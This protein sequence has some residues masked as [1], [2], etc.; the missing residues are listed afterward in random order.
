M[1]SGVGGPGGAGKFGGVPPTGASGAP[2]VPQPSSAERKGFGEA[3]AATGETVEPTATPPLERLRAGEIDLQQYVELR[4][5]EATAHLE[6]SLPAADL[7]VIRAELH[8]VVEQDPDVA[9]L[10]QTARIGS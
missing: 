7:E 3:I 1:V 4:V 10:A 5:R 2:G 8:A 9:A 6:G